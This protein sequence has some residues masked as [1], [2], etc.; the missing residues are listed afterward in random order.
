MT[1]S[2]KQSEITREW[3]IVDAEGQTLGRLSTAIARYLTGKHKPTYTPHMDG[4]DHVV[5][6][7]ASKIHVSGDKL[8][9]K[10]YYRHSGYPGSLRTLTLQQQLDH[11][12]SRVIEM[13]VKGMLP[14]NRLRAERMKRLKVY[15]DSDHPHTAQKPHELELDTTKS[16][17][18]SK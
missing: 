6:V 18:R 5:V 16:K 8:A 17:E 11:N 13:A 4:G 10:R 12:P 9:Q 3:Y 15:E 2:Q 7:N 14:D 1:Y